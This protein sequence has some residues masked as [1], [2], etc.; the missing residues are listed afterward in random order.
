VNLR[1]PV[2]ARAQAAQP[3]EFAAQRVHPLRDAVQPI[4]QGLKLLGTQMKFLNEADHLLPAT[5]QPEPGV[6]ALARRAGVRTGD[7]EVVAVLLQESAQRAEVGLEEAPDTPLGVDVRAQDLHRSV[8]WKT[9]IADFLHQVY[10]P[11]EE[12]IAFQHAPTKQRARVLD[13]PQRADFFLAAE[14]T[15]V[16][17]LRQVNM[18]RIVER[19]VAGKH[20]RELSTMNIPRSSQPPSLKGSMLI[21]GSV[22]FP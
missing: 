15:S 5:N 22:R 7:A 3:G 8:Q 13:L 14:M 19:G 10:Y 18:D 2:R 4:E 6:T 21:L 9:A 16:T 20:D 1:Y 17:H 11:A 12:K